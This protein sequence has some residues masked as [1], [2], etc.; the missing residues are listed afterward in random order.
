MSYVSAWVSANT[1]GSY[2]RSAV[3]GLAIGWYGYYLKF[4][5]FITFLIFIF[6]ISGEI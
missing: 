5:Y 6:L 3:L 4:I 1:E 2:K